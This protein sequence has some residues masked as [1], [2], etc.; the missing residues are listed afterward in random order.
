MGF[1]KGVGQG[2]AGLVAK[3]VSGLVDVVSYTTQGVEAHITGSSI[4]PQNAYRVREPRA[5]YKNLGV[6]KSYDLLHSTIF[7]LIAAKP[8]EYGAFFGA[9]KCRIIK[10]DALSYSTLVEVLVITQNTL[11]SIDDK[12]MEVKW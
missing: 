2:V 8:K 7:R 1:A 9:Y 12:T 5:F 6:I 11:L 10:R 3:P 4:C